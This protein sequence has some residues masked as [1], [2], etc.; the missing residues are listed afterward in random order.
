MVLSVLLMLEE[1]EQVVKGT[2]R[3]CQILTADTTQQPD[4]RLRLLMNLYNAFEPSLEF[5]YRVFKYI[6]DYAHAASLFDQ[7]TPY[8]EYLDSWM[9]DWEIYIIVD[10]KR[11]LYRDL[12]KYVR[13]LG[14]RVDSFLFLKR[15]HQLFQGAKDAELSDASVTACA[16]QLLTDAINIPSAIQFDDIL[17]FDTVKAL[18]KSKNANESGLVKLCEVFLSGTVNTMRDFQKNNESLFKTHDISVEDAMS[19]I[20]LLTL[21]TLARN[22]SEMTL[23]EVAKGLEEDEQGVE[24]WV[25]RAISEGVID[26]RIDQLHSKVIIKSAFQ[27]KFEKEEW[28]FLEDKL[29]CWIDNLESVIDF[30]GRQKHLK[31]GG[32]DEEEAA[33]N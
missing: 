18:S 8:L 23:A 2:T 30:I 10:D 26:G 5:R 7:I 31:V 14:K 16:V 17:A 29:G 12:S 21:A 28:K 9:A 15:Y 3:L 32:A 19:K 6:V 20:R 4:L 11:A 13:G 27:R 1:E 33:T 24:K 22:K 25:V